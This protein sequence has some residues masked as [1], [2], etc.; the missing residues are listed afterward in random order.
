MLIYKYLIINFSI[1]LNPFVV[2]WGVMIS[3]VLSIYFVAMYFK[4]SMR[5]NP[6]NGRYSGYYRLA[7]ECN[8]HECIF[9][10]FA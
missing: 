3:N 6:E 4:I 10:V 8:M 2:H 9:S 7:H 1:F 5:K